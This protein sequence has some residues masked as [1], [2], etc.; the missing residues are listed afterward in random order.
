VYADFHVNYYSNCHET[1]VL[2]DLHNSSSV[3]GPIS[4]SG[5]NVVGATGTEVV[6][7][8]A[9]N[10]ATAASHPRKQMKSLAGECA[11]V[12]AVGSACL[13][14]NSLLY[15]LLMLGTVWLGLSLYNFTK[16]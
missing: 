12:M 14:Q 2:Y 1:I 8:A 7:S 6:S 5:G 4:V 10:V 16:T 9:D 3:S 13:R 11:S 15:L